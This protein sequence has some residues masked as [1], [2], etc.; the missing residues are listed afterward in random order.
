MC[1]DNGKTTV[2]ERILNMDSDEQKK[3][4]SKIAKLEDIEA[5]FA[6]HHGYSRSFAKVFR[7]WQ[8]V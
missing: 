8:G 7:G 4:I 1:W 3:S 5:I 6:A 2:F